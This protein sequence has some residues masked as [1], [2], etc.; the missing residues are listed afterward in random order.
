MNDFQT[1][2]INQCKV[3]FAQYPFLGESNFEPI[4]GSKE[5]YFKAEFSIQDRRLLEV[6]SMKMKLVLWSVAKNGQFAKNL[7]TPP[8]IISLVGL[9]K[10]S[11]KSYLSITRDHWTPSKR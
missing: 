11:I 1:K 5:S 8:R 2:C 10:K 4:Q 7:T 9:L 6:L 3:L